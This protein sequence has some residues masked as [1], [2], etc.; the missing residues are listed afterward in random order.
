MPASQKGLCASVGMFFNLLPTFEVY[1]LF[2]NSPLC[3][4][5]V[6]PGSGSGSPWIRIDL[7]SW[8]RM[9]IE[10]KSRI[11]IRIRIETNADP[12][13]WLKVS[14]TTAN[15]IE[16]FGNQ[17]KIL[18]FLHCEYTENWWSEFLPL[19]SDAVL[20]D[21]HFYSNM[22]EWKWGAPHGLVASYW[23][24]RPPRAQ[25]TLPL[26]SAPLSPSPRVTIWGLLLFP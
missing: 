21:C 15:W 4:F 16:S 18:C 6:W 9:R 22:M 14:R 23:P 13:H 17:A 7:A 20:S 26:S 1:F 24:A 12:Q 11:R 25:C 8:I 19:Y 5:K 3:Y 10:I 2:T